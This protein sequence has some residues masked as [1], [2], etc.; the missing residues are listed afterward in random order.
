MLTHKERLQRRKEIAEAIK[1][2]KL[3]IGEV[4]NR[5]QVSFQTVRQSC[6]EFGVQ[7]PNK[8]RERRK[9]ISQA[10]RQENLSIGQAANKF[11]VSVHTVYKVCIEFG[12][13]LP[14]QARELK[15]TAFQ[16]IALRQKGFTYEQIA[17]QLNLSNQRIQQIVSFAK[18]AGVSGLDVSKK[19][20]N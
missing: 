10:I 2:E 7:L 1:R 11:Q 20:T 17:K 3:S 4:A 12:V 18:D 14:P 19:K 13:Q 8:R 15:I 16:A 6:I 5:F 9:E